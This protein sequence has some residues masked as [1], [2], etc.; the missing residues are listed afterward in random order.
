MVIVSPLN[1]V[2]TLQTGMILQVGGGTMYD[3]VDLGGGWTHQTIWKIYAQVKLRIMKPK[4][5]E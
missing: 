3:T 2:V 5:S 4:F 1:G